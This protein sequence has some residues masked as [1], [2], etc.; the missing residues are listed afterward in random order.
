[1]KKKLIVWAVIVSVL[2]FST[3]L[4]G[5]SARDGSLEIVQPSP[6]D[7]FITSNVEIEIWFDFS[8]AENLS[9]F[10]AWVN[11][12]SVE[13]L[14]HLTDDGLTASAVLSVRDGVKASVNGPRMNVFRAEVEGL[15]GKKRHQ[16]VQ[17]IVDCSGNQTPVAHIELD[18][19]HQRVFVNEIVA[20][21]GSGSFD[22]DQDPLDY[23]W[24]FVSVPKKSKTKFSDPSSA[25][26]LFVPDM[27]GTYVVQL[28]VN[29]YKAKS[30]PKTVAVT[31]EKLKI[32]TDRKVVGPIFEKLSNRATVDQYDGSQLPADYHVVILDGKAHTAQELIRNP[33]LR[34]A[35]AEG[36]WVLVLNVKDDHKTIGVAS[37]LGIGT[38]GESNAYLFRRFHD[39]NIPVFRIFELPL[40][41]L[42][43]T[44]DDEFFLKQAGLLLKEIRESWGVRSIRTVQALPPTNPIPEG[45]IN[46][47]WDYTYPFQWSKNYSGR[48][49]ESKGRIQKGTYNINYTFTLFLDNYNQPMGNKQY[50]LLQID[51]ESNPNNYG[52]TFIAT[53]SDMDKNNE[54]AWFQDKLTMDIKPEDDFWIWVENSPT[55][56]N[57][58]TTYSTSVSFDIGFSQDGGSASFGYSTGSSYTLSDWGISG[59]GSSGPY[60]NW[61]LRSTN[62]PE[63][64]G[65]YF[66]YFDYDWFYWCGK[67][68]RPNAMS[69]GQTQL[70][71]SVV[72]RTEG[73][74]NQVATFSSWPTINVVDNWCPID[75][76]TT[77]C[78]RDGETRK[79]TFVPPIIEWYTD[80]FGFK[81]PKHVPITWSLDLGAVIPIEIEAIT[82]N[83]HPALV[84]T[85][86]ETIKASIV[87]AEPAK[88]DTW[89]TNLAS[90]NIGRAQPKLDRVT[91]QKGKRTANF[92]IDVNAQY[93]NPGDNFFAYIS[94]F[95]A[96]KYT[97]QFAMKAVNPNDPKPPVTSPEVSADY[98]KWSGTTGS[99]GNWIEGYLVRYA[100]SFVYPSGESALGPWSEWIGPGHTY[101]MPL[102]VDIPKDNTNSAKR[103][104]IYRQFFAD[105][106]TADPAGG[107]TLVGTLDDNTTTTYPE[108]TP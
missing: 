83:Q 36:K 77:C 60:Q 102:L 9:P 1:M 30:E 48:Q 34:E 56:P 15:D 14:F 68:K 81:W 64:E 107:V 55:S 97:Q 53:Q 39:G 43:D 3:V 76:G 31:V 21:D 38:K 28:I 80:I 79:T 17:F 58:E 70:H 52:S 16:T 50:L 87:L 41:N 11:G 54:Y 4:Q 99:T 25:G 73:V 92:D 82:F 71:A 40:H 26:P 23:Q 105:Y 95:Y 101:A 100:V 69:M 24:S 74:K 57:Y 12:K 89:I 19:L 20:V 7:T 2:T 18:E 75:Y 85:L 13:S 45:L 44:E 67:P 6:M 22:A 46:C 63:H 32:L 62:P 59:S 106:R 33:L 10:R 84:G 66:K 42:W 72:W 29:D 49:D 27:P 61:I 8:I 91:I 104:K 78:G 90:S 96:K 93:V 94:A 98:G 108:T 86:G 5:V 37:H 103:R 51:A 88:I 65:S 47:R 35:F